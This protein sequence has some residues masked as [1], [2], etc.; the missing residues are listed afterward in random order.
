MNDR[1]TIEECRKLLLSEIIPQNETE[2]ISI[3]DAV[4]RVTAEDIYAKMNVPY[5]PKSAMD[6]YAVGSGDVEGASKEMPVT[7]KVIGELCA[8]DYEEFKYKQG[9]AIRVMTGAYVPEGYNAVIRQE[10]TD[11]GNDEVLIYSDIKE[12][13]NYCKVGEDIKQGECIVPAGV[14]LTSGHIGI[15]ASLGIDEILV[16]RKAKIAIISTGSELTKVGDKLSAGKIYN[17]IEHMLKVDI[18]SKKLDVVSMEICKDEEEDLRREITQ[19]IEKADFVITTGAVSVGKKDIVPKVLSQMGA[20][21]I[22]KGAFIQPGT[23]TMASVLNGKVI[24]SLSGNPYAALA[25]FEIYFWS[26]MAKFMHSD[27]LDVKTGKAI[28]KSEY[29]KQNR[30][31]RLIRAYAENGEV[32]LPSNI[33]SS[34]VIHNLTKCNCMIDLEAGR[35]VGIGD[36]VKLIYIK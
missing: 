12:Y 32:R 26:V 36:E 11:Y 6:G 23:P 1:I 34:S 30:M 21:R 31:R 8:G 4:G 20:K 24:L 35:K 25:N 18:I 7:L 9:T 3:D 33:H 14:C 5:F 28:L 13:T 15:I 16:Y 10:D 22:F 2:K 27:D 17:S 29:N 19:A